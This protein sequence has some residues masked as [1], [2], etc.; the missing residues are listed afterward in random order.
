[1]ID[2]TT[3]NNQATTNTRETVDLVPVQLGFLEKLM[4]VN[5]HLAKP[6]HVLPDLPPVAG[7]A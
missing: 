4:A 6:E 5:G 1:M 3:N 2:Q 7:R